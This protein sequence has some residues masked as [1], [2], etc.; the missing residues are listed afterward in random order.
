MLFRSGQNRQQMEAY[1][2]ALERHARQ[3]AE[4]MPKDAA[5]SDLTL[6]GGTPLLLPENLLRK[7][8]SIARDFFGI[9]AGKHVT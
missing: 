3:F 6:G 8:F 5:F 7:V 9:E 4:I 2:A 1:L